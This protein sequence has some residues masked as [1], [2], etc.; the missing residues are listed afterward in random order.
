VTHFYRHEAG[1][2]EECPL[3]GAGDMG[4]RTVEGLAMSEGV[5]RVTIADRDVSA[6]RETV[7]R[8][9][10]RHAALAPEIEAHVRNR[11]FTE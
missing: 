8:M 4:S 2:G 1:V 5:R 9:A 7:A 10:G 6:A 3:G 11:R